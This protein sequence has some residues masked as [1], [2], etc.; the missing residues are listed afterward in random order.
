MSCPWY[1]HYPKGIPE[2]IDPSQYSSIVQIIDESTKKFSNHKAYTNMGASLTFG[3]VAKLSDNFASFLQNELKL[4]KGDR[5]ALQMPNC[6]QYP[7]AL[8]GA[9]KAGVVVVNTNPLYTAKEMEHQFKDSGIK[10]IVILANFA[11]SLEKILPK[12]PHINIVVTEL[13]DMFSPVKKILV[14]SVVKYVKKMVPKYSLP[15]AYSFNQA[16]AS[17][18]KKKPTKVELKSDD[19]AF[20]QYTGG[21]TGVS[22]G[23]ILTHRNIISNVLQAK[24]WMAPLLK[25]GEEKII[26][27]LPLYHIFSL[28]VNC[29]IFMQKGGENILITNPKDIPAFIKELKGSG[30]TVMTGVNTLFNALM[31]HPGFSEIDFSTVKLSVAGATALQSAV[32]EKWKKLT[33][34]T[35]IEGYGLTEASPIVCCNPVGGGDRVGTI[36]M[37][38]PSTEVK[39]LDDDGKEVVE[40]EPGELCVKGP[41]VMQGY[42]NQPE[43]TAKVIKNGW[44]HTGDIAVCDPSGFFKIV[45]RK[46]DMILVSGFNVYPNEIEEVAAQHPGVLEVAAVGVPDEKSGEAVKLFVVKKDASLT[47]EAL[48]NFCKEKLTN[49][50]RPRSVEWRTE[51]PKTPVGKILRRALRG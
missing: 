50:K 24:E 44:L 10:A 51:L 20:L 37:P 27:A 7:V 18:A 22:K 47:E 48:L 19:I 41:Q 40:G 1:K 39:L 11:T 30:F 29:L 38:V 3:E 16:L 5:I 14:N 21:T 12:F 17:G 31:N 23:A 26:T 35:V 4:K 28:T 9:L 45:D 42:W 32:A 8:F 49:Y 36:G 46:K 2:Q 25:D 34:T 13:G 33:G 15:G 43:E 6:L